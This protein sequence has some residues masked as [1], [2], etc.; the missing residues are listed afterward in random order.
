MRTIETS[1]MISSPPERV[2][3]ILSDLPRYQEWNPFIRRAEGRL[4]VGE[5]LKVFIQPPG[6]KGMTHQPTVIVAE[7]DRRLQWLGRLAVPGLFSARHE[8]VLEP[9]DG[10]TLLRH[11]EVFT[12]ILVPL[13]ARTLDRTE[14]GFDQLNRALKERAESPTE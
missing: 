5:V 8:F 7:P 11:R 2:W 13:L 12:G 3:R 10:G 4:A 14:T 9:A 1:V 6:D